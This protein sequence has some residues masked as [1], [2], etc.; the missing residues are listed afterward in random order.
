[1]WNGWS[2]KP[3]INPAQHIEG[4]DEE[5]YDSAEDDPN[6]LVSPRRPAQSPGHS[7]RRLLQPDPPLVEEVLEHTSRSLRALPQ[8]V[9]RQQQQQQLQQNQNMPDDRNGGNNA[10]AAPAA[11]DFDSEEKADGEKASEQARHI[12]VE[13][14]ENDIRFWFSQLETEMVMSSVGSQWLKKLILQRNLPNKQKEDVKDF[15]V[16]EKTQAGELIY[17]RIKTELIRIYAP[18][19]CDSYVKALTRTMVGLPSQLGHQIVSDVCKKSNKLTG[20]CCPAAVQAL[21]TQKLPISIRAH[22]SNMEFTKETYREVFEAA[23]K[24]F[25]SA[26]QLSVSAVQVAASSLDETLPAFDQQNQPQVAAF[27]RGG[28]GQGRGQRG[29]RGGSRGQ[30]RGNRG[31]SKDNKPRGPK[32]SS[33]PPDGVCDRHYR[34]GPESWYCTAPHTCPWVDKT[35][36]KP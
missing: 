34:H 17:K 16:L 26:K 11:V 1:M 24:V 23:D 3:V 14:D 4:E 35:V 6:L 31:G 27:G 22:I 33:N 9:A 29:G 8:R 19:P 13:F 7:P 5:N 2:F 25:L 30:G 15:L 36:Q 21:W 18:K 28:K 32:H 12:K 10:A 20:C